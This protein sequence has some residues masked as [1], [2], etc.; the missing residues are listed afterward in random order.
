MPNWVFW[1]AVLV[2]TSVGLLAV[3]ASNLLT[4]IL[5]WAALDMIELMILIGQLPQS[6]NRERVIIVFTAR[7]AGIV[8]VLIAGLLL[9][10]QGSTLQLNAIPPSISV[11]L[12]LAAAIRLGIF[13]PQHRYTQGLLVRSDLA[14]VIN[15]ISAATC[16][17]LL[18]R[19]S[20]TGITPSITPY[21]LGF[22]TLVGMYAAFRWLGAK[23]E[24]DGRPYWMLGTA[25]LAI[26]ASILNSPLACLVWSLASLLS[27]G[28]IFSY[29]LRHR[30]IIPLIVL[31][32]FN[33][34]TL[35]F[36]PTWQGTL[37][38]QSI[39]SVIGNRVLF[40]LFSI[41]FL[42]IQA[43]LLSG[44]IRHFLAGVFPVKEEKSQH[45]ER[46]V[47]VLYPLGLI[48]IVAAHLIIGWFLLPDLN[49]LP[50]VAW[51]IGPVTLLIAAIIL[52]ISWRL[53]QPFHIPQKLTKTSFWNTLFSFEWLYNFIWNAYRTVSRLFGVISTILE[54]DGGILWAL[55]LFALIFVF[56]QR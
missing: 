53:P 44:Y 25:S 2:L 10:S 41:S 42:F 20:S 13:P 19:V 31:G 34:S 29:S 46:W 35:P 54:G 43:L 40:L 28:L 9:S 14:T 26:A 36:S 49:G 33:L 12:I 27:G 5:A 52:F 4:L 24:I 32:V 18:V 6:E 47:W 7:L 8:T 37:I 23:D 51:I 50:L 39:S 45:I 48:L 56:L 17:I 55:V 1:V 30:N 16:F 21:L 3:T 38:Y 11:I 22:F 15:L